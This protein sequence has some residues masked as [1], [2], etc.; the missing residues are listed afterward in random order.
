MTLF[1][2]WFGP[3]ID[4]ETIVEIWK[5]ILIKEGEADYA[6]LALGETTTW[7][8]SK[9]D[10]LKI[11]DIPQNVYGIQEPMI[12]VFACY[13]GKM[14]CLLFT[15]QEFQEKLGKMPIHTPEEQKKFL[16]Y[17]TSKYELAILESQK[18]KLEL[19]LELGQIL[20][21][22]FQEIKQVLQTLEK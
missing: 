4:P 20:L 1:Q 8:K 17:F 16:E 10:L 5:F 21:E 22:H 13:Y 15:M 9:K 2:L 7:A 6:S 3:K 19:E 14:L 18:K 11:L 12:I